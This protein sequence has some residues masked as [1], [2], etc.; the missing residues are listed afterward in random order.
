MNFTT[1]SHLEL[2]VCILICQNINILISTQL[3]KVI[4]HQFWVKKIFPWKLNL[5]YGGSFTKLFMHVSSRNMFP[6]TR[7]LQIRV[8]VY[9]P[10]HYIFRVYHIR[11]LAKKKLVH[12]TR[13]R[14]IPQKSLSG[15]CACLPQ[16]PWLFIFSSWGHDCFI[17]HHLKFIKQCYDYNTQNTLE[18]G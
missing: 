1:F 4:L 13:N 2:H 15:M 8:H 5:E 18:F 6:T 12:T 3:L 10:R 7:N 16:H 9:R 14:R 17:A 11:I